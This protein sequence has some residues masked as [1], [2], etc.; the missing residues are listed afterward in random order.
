MTENEV[1]RIFRDS[2]INLIVEGANE[3]MQS[4]VF[5][6]GGKQLAEYMLGVKL[7]PWGGDGSPTTPDRQPRA[8]SRASSTQA[9]EGRHPAGLE[10]F[11]GIRGKLPQINKRRSP[12]LVRRERLC[13]L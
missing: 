6:Y 2:R 5:G 12:E 9:H 3:V 11:L 13:T 7:P 1:E 10:V 4:Y 8:R